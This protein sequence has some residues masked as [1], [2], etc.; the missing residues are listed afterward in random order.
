MHEIWQ[1]QTRFTQRRRQRVFRM[2]A[3]PRFRAAFDFLEL[4]AFGAPEL[5][6]ELAFWRQAQL[7][8]PEQLVQMIPAKKNSGSDNTDSASLPVKRVRRRSKPKPTSPAE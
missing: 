3:H 6:E 7:A 1:L 4:R 5:E 2:L 8:S